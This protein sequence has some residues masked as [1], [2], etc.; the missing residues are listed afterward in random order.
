MNIEETLEQLAQQT[1]PR[2][3]DVVDSVMATVSQHPYLRPVS[4]HT[5]WR[6]IGAAAAAAVA[7]LLAVGIAVPLLRPYDEDDMSSMIAQV[8]DY[9]AWTSVEDVAE[10]PIEFLY[11]E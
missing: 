8:N 9:S 5:Y 3:V 6:P 11:E 7:L 4:K 2:K 10:N 1:C